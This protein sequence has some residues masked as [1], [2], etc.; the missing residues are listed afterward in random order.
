MRHLSISMIVLTCMFFFAS[1][2]QPP[3]FLPQAEQEDVF[4][5]ETII[6]NTPIDPDAIAL[7]I[8]DKTNWIQT[9]VTP[10]EKAYVR[11]GKVLSYDKTYLAD[12]IAHYTFILAG[13]SGEYDKI[14][15]HRVVREN[16][17]GRPVRT[18]KALF[19]LHG[20]ANQFATVMLPGVNAANTPEDFGLSV[21]LAQNGVDV[22][23]IDQAWSLVPPEVTD[24][25][26]MEDWGMERQI[27]DSRIA[28]AVAR[29]LRFRTGSGINKL[30]ISG[31][32]S[33]GILGYAI[34]NMEA[35]L[36]PLA[37]QAKGFISMD[38]FVK[39]Q[40]EAYIAQ[41]ASEYESTSAML[42]SGVYGSSFPFLFVGNLAIN[43]PGGDS[44]VIP[45]FTNRQAAIF[46][47]SG[48]PTGP[49]HFLAGTWE[50]GL[51]T[52]YQYVET[53]RAFDIYFKTAT[54]QATRYTH[55]INLW[56]GEVEDAPWDDHFADI[57]VPILSI[58]PAG[59]WGK[60]NEY[61]TTFLGSTDITH[62]YIQL[63][64][65]GQE[66]TD[67]GHIDI[68]LANNAEELAWQPILEWIETH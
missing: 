23:G 1:C 52:G 9:E 6:Q 38:A 13:G 4:D 46:L 39:L 26:F 61:T 68:F 58:D 34:L 29:I 20:T 16:N 47:F 31:H 53:E 19:H 63:N 15:L 41:F 30:V 22:W 57:T 44:P 62:H 14:G 12:G 65:D 36:I 18:P 24:H 49:S 59:G 10:Q 8:L 7:E 56:L 60:L 55:D 45:G 21:Y 11:P 40:N 25:S 5:L 37:R 42:E 32:S 66:T 35:A 3:D 48:R 67:Y 43:D 64:E 27:R 33:G 28:L 17:N 2:Q 50:N 51:P 54:Y